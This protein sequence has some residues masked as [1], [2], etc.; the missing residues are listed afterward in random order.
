MTELLRDENT[1][2]QRIGEQEHILAEH[3][4][5]NE[6][7][8]KLA[9]DLSV[10]AEQLK[11]QPRNKKLKQDEPEALRKLEALQKDAPDRE[12][13]HQKTLEEITRLRENVEVNRHH[14]N[15]LEKPSSR[16]PPSNRVLKRTC[17]MR[18]A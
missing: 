2:L 3:A 7:Q 16:L 17:R 9:A 6:Q 10:I 5:Q 18:S 4:K 14:N 1:L 15:K 8:G 13:R 11:L 12:R